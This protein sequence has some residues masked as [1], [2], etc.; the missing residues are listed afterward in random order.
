MKNSKNDNSKKNDLTHEYP[1]NFDSCDT[2]IKDFV[3]ALINENRKLQRRLAKLQAER[4]SHINKIKVLEKESFGPNI[5]INV[6]PAEDT[7]NPK[8]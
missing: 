2:N 6:K 7:Q 8:T 3:D 1:E 5:N 4:I